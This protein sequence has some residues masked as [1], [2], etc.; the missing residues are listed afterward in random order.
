MSKARDRFFSWR[1]GLRTPPS[2]ALPDEFETFQNVEV[3]GGDCESRDGLVRIGRIA[4]TD[5]ILNYDGSNDVVTVG[6]PSAIIPLPTVFTWEMLF[7]VDD[8]SSDRY[9]VGSTSAAA[10][11]LAIRQTTSETVVAV[12]TDSAANTVTLTWTGIAAE[13]VCGIQIVRDGADVTGW[14]NGTTK[15]GTLASATNSLSSANTVFGKNNSSGFLDGAIDYARVWRVARST[16]KDLFKRLLNPRNKDVLADWVFTQGSADDVLDRGARGI[17]LVTTGSPAFDR[18]PLALNPAPIQAI[19]YC[20]R[21]NA[22]RE[23]VVMNGGREHTMT[24]T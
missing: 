20:V 21:R 1:K 13:T 5:S 15:T 11:G 24:V 23:L 12:L 10:V 19:A 3:D 7:Q 6:A 22:T 16:Q 4:N 2:G 18:A 8:L 14:L 9:L 17:H